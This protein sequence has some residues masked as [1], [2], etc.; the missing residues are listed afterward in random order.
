MPS[1]KTRILSGLLSGLFLSTL[2]HAGTV[3]GLYFWFVKRNGA[4]IVAD[5]DL[6]LSSLGHQT[7]PNAGGGRARP[8]EEWVLPAKHKNRPTPAIPTPKSLDVP[9]PVSEE[10][11]A[12]PCAEPC[13]DGDGSGGG[14]T[15]EGHGLY[16][17]VSETSKKPRWVR[18]FIND[19]DYPILARQHGKDG[20]VVLDVFIDDRGRVRDA[21][22]L[23][24]AYEALNEVALRKVLGAEFTPAYDAD[25]RAV[26]C[27]VTLPIRFELR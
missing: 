3:G 2:V 27:R 12:A 18:N 24:G 20:R 23:Q 19:R 7:P 26:G 8:A 25:G 11:E 6:S 22:L 16:V 13:S 4:P 14:G 10:A 9:A 5:L 21:R 1:F 15:G 17:P